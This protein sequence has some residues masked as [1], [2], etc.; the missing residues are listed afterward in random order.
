MAAFAQRINTL[1]SE[2][3]HCFGFHQGG[4]TYIV[5]FPVTEHAKYVR[6]YANVSSRMRLT[7]SK[8]TENVS[9]VVKQGLAEDFGITDFNVGEIIINEQAI[10]TISK[11]I[12]INKT[13]LALQEMPLTEFIMLPFTKNLGIVMPV[14]IVV[15]EDKQIVFEAQVV[16]PVN[17]PDLFQMRL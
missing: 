12:N 14:E 13:A 2:H 17:N 10:L 9:K 6:K 16:N 7:M 11:K 8:G 15:D 5:G 4:K 3:G 1:H